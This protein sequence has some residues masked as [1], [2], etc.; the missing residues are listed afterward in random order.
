MTGRRTAHPKGDSPRRCTG[1]VPYVEYD[2]VSAACADCGRLFPSEEALARHRRDAHAREESPR[3]A[4]ASPPVV[5]AVCRK[6]FR[7]VDAL[8]RHNRAQHTG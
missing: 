7:S 1:A 4:P 8:A 5:C 6:R 3:E 2:E